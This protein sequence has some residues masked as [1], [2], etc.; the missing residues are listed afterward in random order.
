VWASASVSGNLWCSVSG[1][2]SAAAIPVADTM[3]II[4]YGYRTS[5]VLPWNKIRYILIKV[6]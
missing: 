5:Y 3:P 4:I 6:T 1:R 2:N